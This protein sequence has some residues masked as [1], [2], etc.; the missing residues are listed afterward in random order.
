MSTF[1][2]AVIV[3]AAIATA[4]VPSIAHAE[5]PAKK[6]APAIHMCESI[7]LYAGKVDSNTE[8]TRVAEVCRDVSIKVAQKAIAKCAAETPE[9]CE[10]LKS[11]DGKTLM[12][13]HKLSTGGK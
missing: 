9:T 2:R 10:V 7:D 12:I 4:F 6:A 8:S 11:A 1:V 13:E 5:K 3:L